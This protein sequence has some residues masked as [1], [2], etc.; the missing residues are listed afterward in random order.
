MLVTVGLV[1]ILGLV[2]CFVISV[3][4]S[5]SMLSGFSFGF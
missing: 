3:V 2:V 4:Y 5:W 1:V